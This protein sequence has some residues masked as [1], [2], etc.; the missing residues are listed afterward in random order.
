VLWR[1]ELHPRFNDGIVVDH[2]WPTVEIPIPRNR[3][4]LRKQGPVTMRVKV[5]A[6]TDFNMNGNMSTSSGRSV[7]GNLQGSGFIG[8][9]FTMTAQ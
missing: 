8:Q 4:A 2:E 3:A 1:T 6:F 7:S 5:G 9:P